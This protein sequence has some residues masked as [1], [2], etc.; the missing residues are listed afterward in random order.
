MDECSTIRNAESIAGIYGHNDRF[1]C[2]DTAVATRIV[3]DI[4]MRT[5][6]ILFMTGKVF[7]EICDKEEEEAL[8]P[9]KELASQLRGDLEQFVEESSLVHQRNF[10]GW[11]FTLCLNKRSYLVVFQI[12]SDNTISISQIGLLNFW[13][14]LKSRKDSM[15]ELCKQI[16]TSASSRW[17]LSNMW[18]E[19]AFFEF[20][21]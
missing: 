10:Y 9:G 4:R 3:K 2:S 14:G 21:L 5:G 20:S 19:D 11:E 18:W 1:K 8:P 15:D 16:E 17:E 7:N 12:G 13:F 6:R